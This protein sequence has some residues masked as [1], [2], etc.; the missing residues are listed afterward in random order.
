MKRFWIT[1][2]S[3]LE[4]PDKQLGTRQGVIRIGNFEERFEA[5]LEYWKPNHYESQWA[6]AITR[7]CSQTPKSC[8]ITSITDP[9]TANFLFWWPMYLVGQNVYFR[10]H[11]L[12]LADITSSF[13]PTNPYPHIPD[14]SVTNEDGERIS[15][16]VIPFSDFVEERTALLG[17]IKSY[18]AIPIRS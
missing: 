16:W 18:S 11:I 1:F 17:S 8:L 15:E 13:D 12:F 4:Q 10:N 7:L 5:S 3:E 9:A 14:R 6:N 2:L